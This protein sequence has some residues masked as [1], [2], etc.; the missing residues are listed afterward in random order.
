MKHRYQ[1]GHPGGPGRPKLPQEIRQATQYTKAM[2][3]E[4]MN[5]LLSVDKSELQAIMEEPTTP[6]LELIVGS[7]IVNAIKH[8]DPS[9]LN[10]LLDRIIGRVKDIDG[11]PKED[12]SKILDLI[13]REKLRMLVGSSD[14]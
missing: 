14:E 11:E 8:G 10:F 12:K 2:I 6:T 3:L 1:V 7:I 5:K 9:R 4:A 13:P